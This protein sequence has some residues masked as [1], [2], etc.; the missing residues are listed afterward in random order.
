MKIP[1]TNISLDELLDQLPFVVHFVDNEGILRWQNKTAA[2]LPANQPRV[3]GANIKDCH[4]HAESVE[5][6]GRIFDDFRKGRMEPHYYVTPAGNK[7][8]KI[9]VYDADGKFAGILSYS[10]PTG[11]PPV[12][13]TF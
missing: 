3:I 5:E 6:V 1:N 2:A 10:H 11:K 8:V 12:E 9:P 4:A 7:A 13:R